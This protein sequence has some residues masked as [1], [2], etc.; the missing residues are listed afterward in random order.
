MEYETIFDYNPTQGELN[1]FGLGTPGGMQI[2]KEVEQSTGYCANT[3]NYWLGLLFSMRGDNK[4]ANEYWNKITNKSML[5][6]L[7]EDC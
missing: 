2:Y 1:R 3:H 7:I 5:S 4:K 6:T